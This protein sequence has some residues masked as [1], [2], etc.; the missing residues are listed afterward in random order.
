MSTRSSARRL[1]SPIKDPERLFSQRNRSELSLPFDLEEDDMARQVPSHGP[2]PDLRPMEELLQA[3]TDGV[4]DAIVSDVVKLLLFSFSLEGAARTW[5]EKEP[6]NSITTWNDLVS[7]FV[8]HFF[9]SS[10][11]TNLQNEIMR[12]QQRFGETF[13]E[14][15]DRFKDL[16]NKCPHHGFSPLYQI[17]TFYNSLNQSE[18]DSLNSAAGGNFLTMNTQEALTIIE[19]KSKF[20]TSRNKPQVA[21]ASG[22]STQDAALTALTK[23]VEALVFMNRPIN[24]IRNGCETCGGPHAYYECQAAGGYTQDVYATSGTYNQGGNAYQPQGN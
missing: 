21:S 13:A 10:K 15:W 20:Q 23:Q 7:K 14:A 16:L 1:L 9:S 18:Q 19:N 6:P 3:P 4:G 8:N 24:L 12:F 22:S 5:L 11:T 2:I 17:D